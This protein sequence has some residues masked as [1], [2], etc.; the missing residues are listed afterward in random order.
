D[1]SVA[2]KLQD[3]LI[4]SFQRDV[5][6]GVEAQQFNHLST[7]LDPVILSNSEDRWV[8]DLNGDGEFRVKDVMNLLDEFF[9]PKA[10]VPTRWVKVIPIKVNIFAWKMFLNRLP[11]RSNLAKRNVVI[12]SESCSLC[13]SAQE[14]VT[15]V[16]FS[17]TLVN[18]LTR[19]ICRWWNLE[20]HSFSLYAEWLRWLNSLRLGN[21]MLF[22]SNKPRKESIFD[23]IVLRSF[24]WCV[25]RD[26]G[27]DITLADTEKPVEDSVG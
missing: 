17:C 26:F 8:C 11:T 19:L 27:D 10:D 21:H 14:D 13:D 4:Y 15:H 24:N 25:A 16:F 12:E 3:S 20:A 1:I 9:L 7:L 18:D 22:A 23:D 2:N 5:R 6:G